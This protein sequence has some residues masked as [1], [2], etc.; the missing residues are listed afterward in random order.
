[1]RKGVTVV[2]FLVCLV[3]ISTSIFAQGGKDTA[4][5]VDQITFK[6]GWTL[7]EAAAPWKGET[8]RFIGES[9]PPLEALA[10][11][12]EEFE[13]ITGVTVEIEQYGQAEVIQKTMADFVGKTQIYD[14]ILSPHRQL[15]TYVE[16]NWLYPLDTFLTHPKLHDPAFDIQGGAI[17]DE[18][19]WSEVSWYNDTVYGLP[20]H[21]ISMYMWYRYDVFEHPDEMRAFKQK[22]GYELPSPPVTMQ[23]FYDTAEFFTRKKGERLAGKVLTED[24]Y[25]VTLMGKRHVSTWYDFLNILYAFGGR[26]LDI[27]KGAEYGPVVINS[28]EAVK[29]MEFYA[30]MAK[31]CP[32]GLLSAGW[33]ESQAAMQQNIAVMGLEWDDAVG[34]VENPAESLVAGRIAYSGIPIESEKAIQIEGWN[35]HIPASSRKPELAWLFVQWAM[36]TDVQK[37]Q[38]AR[39]GQSAIRAVYDD[40]EVLSKPYVPTAIYLKTGGK[41]ILALR[42]AGAKDGY[43]LPETFANAV[44]PKTGDTSVSLVPKPTFPEQEEVMQEI[45]LAVSNTLSGTMTAKQALDVAAENIANI[46]K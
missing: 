37:E 21:F 39:G 14:M 38:M 9:L 34:A 46:I 4:N 40:P 1:M 43:G 26:D 17:L 25:G 22:Y 13:E 36:G 8:L 33:D 45:L 18:K 16:N 31:F 29:A 30:S 12:K 23:Q 32:P 15:G 42:K 28:P 35:Y 41:E 3:L 6:D 11:V 5:K 2:L 7:A 24:V 44:N 27:E 10:E 20:F 19:Y